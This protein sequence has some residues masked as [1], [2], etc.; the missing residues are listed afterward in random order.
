MTQAIGEVYDNLEIP[1]DEMSMI[2]DEFLI[3][4]GMLCNISNY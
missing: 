1:D 4:G 3:V 2:L